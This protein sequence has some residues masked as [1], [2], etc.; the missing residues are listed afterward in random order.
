MSSIATQNVK[1]TPLSHPAGL[2]VTGIHGLPEGFPSA[3]P[4]AWVGEDLASKEE[5]WI[6]RLNSIECIEIAEG[7]SNF[8]GKILMPVSCWALPTEAS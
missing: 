4:H 3:V 8:K 2:S 7:L 6:Y 5:P 1:P